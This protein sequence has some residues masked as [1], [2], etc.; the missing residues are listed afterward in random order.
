MASKRSGIVLSA[1]ALWFCCQLGTRQWLTP[2]LSPQV[3]PPQETPPSPVPSPP[4]SARRW[5]RNFISFGVPNPQHVRSTCAHTKGRLIIRWYFSRHHFRSVAWSF[6]YGRCKDTGQTF[7]WI[8]EQH[9]SDVG[10]PWFLSSI[11]A[12]LGSGVIIF[13]F[14][15]NKGR[16]TDTQLS[17]EFI[18]VWGLFTHILFSYAVREK[19]EL[20]WG[21]SSVIQT[22]PCLLCS[23]SMHCFMGNTI[24][25]YVSTLR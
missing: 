23:D 6:S 22:Y 4:A 19:P 20:H 2:A 5:Q 17:L 9:R 24:L 16:A 15:K 14:T 25:C 10:M 21:Q 1:K 12:L 7:G 8:F 13:S 18:H 3:Q 11:L